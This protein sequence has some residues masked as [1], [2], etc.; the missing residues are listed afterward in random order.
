[1]ANE[2]A[3]LFDEQ[4]LMQHRIF[5]MAGHYEGVVC[6]GK[7]LSHAA[8]L[9]MHHLDEVNVDSKSLE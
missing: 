2:I 3:R 1:M 6:F 4:N 7:D 9:L 8:E 5:A